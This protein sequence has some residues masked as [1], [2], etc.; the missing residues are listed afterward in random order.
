MPFLPLPPNGRFSLR[1][2]Y[3]VVALSAIVS[4]TRGD[5]VWG[6]ELPQIGKPLNKDSFESHLGLERAPL[7]S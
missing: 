7:G 6:T 1:V 4:Y 2:P 5:A 3:N